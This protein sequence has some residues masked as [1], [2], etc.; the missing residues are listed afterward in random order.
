MTSHRDLSSVIGSEIHSLIAELFPICRSITGDGVRQTL[1]R[2][3]ELIPLTIHELPSGTPVL[4]WTVPDEWNFRSATLHGP[5]GELIIDASIHSLSI[6]NY[7]I[8]FHG[9]LP[10]SQLQEH[11]F[12]LP[13][14]P[15]LIPYRTSYYKEQ[16]GFC[17]PDRIRQQLPDGMYTVA[18]DTTLAPGSLTYGELYLPGQSRRE[19]I[20]SAHICHPSLANDNLSGIAVCS[21]LAKHLMQ[22]N[23]Q[24]SYRFLFMPGTIGALCWLA[25]N[26]DALANVRHGLIVA[27]VGDAGSF[28]YKQS[29]TAGA[30]IDRIVPLVCKEL[31]IPVTVRPFSPYGYDERQFCSPG[32]DLPFGLLSRSPHGSFP[33]YHTSADNLSFVKAESLAQSLELFTALVDWIDTDQTYQNL[34][35]FG[36][37]QLGRRGLYRSIGGTNAGQQEMAILWML[38]LSDGSHSLSAI[39]D[40][41]G[42]PRELLAQ[43][44]DLLVAHQL[45]TRID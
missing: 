40:R 10:L 32:F 16:W 38:N 44:A 45:L 5:N 43:T 1:K 21:F 13:N 17:L 29:R 28:H 2:L 27:N 41:S 20:F 23:R 34:A 12:S 39:A 14:Q 31:G 25:R 11:L 26:R 8:P 35:P 15:D 6:L 7:S 19:L 42:L 18:I 37:P 36:E 3:Q 22:T 9:R 33:E 4:D 24:L 30:D